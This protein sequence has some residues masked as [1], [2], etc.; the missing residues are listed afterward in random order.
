[1]TKS[2]PIDVELVRSLFEYAP[3]LG[4]SCLRWKINVSKVK[5][6]DRAGSLRYSG[7]WYI[8]ISGK[9]YKAHRLVWAIVKGEDPPCHIDHIQGKEVGNNIENLRLALRNEK[10]NTQNA[11]QYKN[12]T[13][14]FTGVSWQKD[15]G[16][17]RARIKI[18]RKLKSLGYFETAQEAY[19]AYL[20]AKAKL[21]I[22]NPVP[23]S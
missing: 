19:D 8:K 3:E 5:A 17:W 23:R 1:M 7:Y 10:D 20:K 18:D 12:N 15:R 21:H 22:F 4:G 13:S 9:Y 2:K 11:R 14:G 16:K 6:G